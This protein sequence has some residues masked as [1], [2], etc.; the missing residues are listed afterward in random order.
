MFHLQRWRWR[1]RT[2]GACS[3]PGGALL[4]ECDPRQAPALA[5]LAAAAFPQAHVA[6]QRD[7]AGRDRVLEVVAYNNATVESTAPPASF[8][9]LGLAAPVWPLLAFMGGAHQHLPHARLLVDRQQRDHGVFGLERRRIVGADR[10]TTPHDEWQ[11]HA[12]RQTEVAERSAGSRALRT[13][14]EL[15]QL[16]PGAAQR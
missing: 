6:V 11:R 16:D 13:D 10:L 15:H 1:A 9:R 2:R 12:R 3:A 7:L 5:A 14:D 8:F 4:M